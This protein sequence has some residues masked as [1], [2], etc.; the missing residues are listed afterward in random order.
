MF[1]ENIDSGRL[2]NDKH[3][4]FCLEYLK[5]LNASQAA[6]R[7][8][9]GTKYAKQTAYKLLKRDDIRQRITQLKEERI[10]AARIDANYVLKRLLTI[11]RLNVRDLL[12]ENGDLKDVQE[13]T[14][15]WQTSI[16]ALDIQVSTTGGVRTLTKK[17][18]LPDRLRNL[19]M[20]GK[21]ID[22]S[23]FKEKE[24]GSASSDPAAIVVEVVSQEAKE[25]IER[26]K[27]K[28]AEE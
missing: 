21:H 4:L 1:M 20:L 12:D 22:V 23:A 5:D 8:G 27:Q 10:R 26:L 11:D 16:Q 18:K 14:E 9:Y 24:N 17:V 28:L 15:D 6:V 7:A 2:K 19:E 3:E 13:W 25:G